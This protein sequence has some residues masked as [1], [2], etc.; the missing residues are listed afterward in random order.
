MTLTQRIESLLAGYRLVSGPR[1]ARVEAMRFPPLVR[2]FKELAQANDWLPP[3]Q[4]T[5]AIFVAHRL[6]L[7]GDLSSAIRGRAC[8][9]YISLVVQFHA[10]AVLKE[11][12]PMVLWDDV[13]DLKHG[14]DL[15][16][17]AADGTV[18]G[19]A[20]MCPTD[21]SLRQAERKRRNGD[22]VPFAVRE[23]VVKERGYMAGEYW[24][25]APSVLIEATEAAL[26]EQRARAA[27]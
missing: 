18:A 21:T 2:L 17:I 24:L 19:L 16:V 9:A 1:D 20:L 15:L 13:L 14:V 8:R 6:G 27:R 11:R 26:A 22:G 7:N 23:L 3:P 25:Y 4:E 10:L 12:Y 5:F